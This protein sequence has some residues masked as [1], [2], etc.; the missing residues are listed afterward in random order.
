MLN[1]FS[2]SST[3]RG[4]ITS[5]KNSFVIT[6]FVSITGTLT[7]SI[8]NHTKRIDLLRSTKYRL[9]NK[10]NVKRKLLTKCVDSIK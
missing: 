3:K 2:K 4:R 5:D 10:S 1:F 9:F 6:N 8:S 7:N